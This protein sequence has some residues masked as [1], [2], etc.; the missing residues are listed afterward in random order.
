MDELRAKHEQLKGILRS[1]GSVAVAYSGGVDSTFLLRVAVDELGM[2]KVLGIIAVSESY[3]AREL[4]EAKQL[5]DEM[6]AR[7][8]VI[9]TDELSNPEYAKNPADRCAICKTELF[10]KMFPIAKEEGLQFLVY[11]VNADDM[12]DFRPGIAAA[13][14]MGARGPLQEA[15]LTKAEIRQLSR[16]LGLRTWD[17]PAF[18][19]LSSRI[20]YGQRITREALLQVDAAENFIRDL[21]FRQVRVRHHDKIAR[22]ELPPDQ[23]PQLF[24]GGFADLV[25]AKLKELGYLYVTVDIQG[26]RVGSLNE[27]LRITVPGK[28]AQ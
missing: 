1:M 2:D 17:K 13:K 20:P 25:A 3:P 11:G 22:I 26:Y 4:E 10:G 7:I 12:G 5:A 27:A 23:I 21:G 14:R 28:T 6:G 16:E 19:C 9:H 18:A 24:A 8:R 15:G